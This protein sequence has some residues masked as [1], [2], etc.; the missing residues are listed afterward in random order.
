[1]LMKLESCPKQESFY[2]IEQLQAWGLRPRTSPWICGEIENNLIWA[3]TNQL[4]APTIA[5]MRSTMKSIYPNDADYKEAFNALMNELQAETSITP[6]TLM[7][8]F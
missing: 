3:G 8:S 6:K 2:C 5:D 7:A 4:I 1:M